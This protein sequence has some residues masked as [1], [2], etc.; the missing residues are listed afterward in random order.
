[1]SEF[2]KQLSDNEKITYMRALLRVLNTEKKLTEPNKIY[3]HRQAEEINLSFADLRRI[4]SPATDEEL[5]KDLKKISNSRLRHYIVREMIML[6][7]ADHEISDDEM[8]GI[9]SLGMGVGIKEDK[10]NDF[11]IWAAQGIEWQIAG[12]RLIEK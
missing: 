5:L 2:K 8:K 1:M 9:Y 4:K 3:L 12:E 10:I 7:M 11:F 6:S